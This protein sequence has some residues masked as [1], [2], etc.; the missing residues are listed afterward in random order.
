[1]N[2]ESFLCVFLM[3]GGTGITGLLPFALDLLNKF[4]TAPDKTVTRRV[5]ILWCLEYNSQVEPVK[6]D[7]AYLQEHDKNSVSTRNQKL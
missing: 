4:N 2:A 7:L 1:M 6:K 5:N 3:A